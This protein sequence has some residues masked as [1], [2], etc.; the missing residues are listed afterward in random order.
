MGRMHRAALAALLL[1]ACGGAIESQT[2]AP[3]AAP[4]SIPADACTGVVGQ[5]R[6]E[7]LGRDVCCGYTLAELEELAAGDGGDVIAQGCLRELGQ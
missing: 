7:G 2:A 3:D 5:L 1:T 4:L 6:S